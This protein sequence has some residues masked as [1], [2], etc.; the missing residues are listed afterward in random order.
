[1]SDINERIKK[2]P[3]AWTIIALTVINLGIF[4]VYWGGKIIIDKT[5]DEVIERLQKDYS[6][7]PYGPGFDP[8]RVDPNALRRDII[9]LEAAFDVNSGHKS[10]TDKAR[11]ADDWRNG[12]EKS[13]G[14]NP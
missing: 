11:K 14:A 2:N 7:S 10:I 1:M 5:A 13:R 3:F 4:S 8:D 6:P 9:G 12:W